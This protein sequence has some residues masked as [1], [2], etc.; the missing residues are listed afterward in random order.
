MIEQAK[1]TYSSLAK[2]LEKQ[3]ETIEDQE[4]NPHKIN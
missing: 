1:I 3:S 2:A 4:K